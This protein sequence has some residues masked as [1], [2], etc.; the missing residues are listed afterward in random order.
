MAFI[1]TDGSNQ[2]FAKLCCLL[3]DYLNQAAGGEEN[4]KQY[5]QYNTL[6]DIKD[7]VLAYDGA[8]PIGCAS[9]KYYEQGIAEVKRVFVK[10][11]YRGKGISKQL[12]HLVEQRAAEKGFATLILETSASLLEAVG[13]YYKMGYNTID[14]YG[15][16]KDLT[17]SVC[18]QKKLS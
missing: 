18:M 8:I 16:Y 5:I 17:E 3:D 4:R 9:F 1:Y 13:L 11:E 14:N 2:D 15:Q 12:M 10:E 6:N 7:V